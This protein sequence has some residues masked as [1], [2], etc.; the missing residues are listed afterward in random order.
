MQGFGRL[1]FGGFQ[2]HGAADDLYFR[3]AEPVSYTH[4]DVYKRQGITTAANMTG[5]FWIDDIQLERGEASNSFNLLENTELKSTSCWTAGNTP[6]VATI[7]G[8]PDSTCTS[9]LKSTNTIRSA[10]KYTQTVKV[11]GAK[12]D[13]FSFGGWGKADSVALDNTCLL[14]TSRCV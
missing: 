3:K 14:Y 13:V 12:G 7:S 6:A 11:N 10:A 5:T 9:A 1:S 2:V 4:L 8:F